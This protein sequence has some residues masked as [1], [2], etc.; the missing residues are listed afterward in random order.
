LLLAYDGTDFRGAAFQSDGPTII[1]ALTDAL[2]LRLSRYPESVRSL[3]A[4][5]IALAGRTDAGVHGWGQVVS[6]LLPADCDLGATRHGLNTLL[7]K[8]IVVRQLVWASDVGYTEEFNAR[9]SAASRT[10]RYRVFNS[11][12]CPPTLLA[13]HW[14]VREPLDIASMNL[15]CD[16]LLGEHNFAS[17]C[18][19]SVG[20]D[21]VAQT[22]NRYLMSAVWRHVPDRFTDEESNADL[23]RFPDICRENVLNPGRSG[24]VLE[25][26]IT[27]NAFCN[28]MVRAIVGLCVAVGRPSTPLRAGDVRELLL[29][30]NRDAA[31]P[32]APAQGLTLWSVDY[33]SPRYIPIGRRS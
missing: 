12:F 3:E 20:S 13:T 30:R 2:L 18:R 23:G 27:A 25:F 7:G 22:L 26:E 6:L 28:Q 19:A 21:G 29:A 14:W 10:Y 33:N 11:W 17:F 32:V 16:P 1:G 15:A 9:Y 24:R 5:D 8:V 4:L 31:P